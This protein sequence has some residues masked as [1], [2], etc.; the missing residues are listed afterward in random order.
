MLELN[1]EAIHKLSDEICRA[2]LLLSNFQG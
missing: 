2:I 1:A